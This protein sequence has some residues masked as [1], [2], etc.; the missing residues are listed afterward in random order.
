MVH[1]SETA[2]VG[3]H[4]TKDDVSPA[5]GEQLQQ[6]GVRAGVSDIMTGQE[7]GT[8]QRLYVQ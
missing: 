8:I 2:G 6:L 5:V 1:L 3:R 4:V 7:V